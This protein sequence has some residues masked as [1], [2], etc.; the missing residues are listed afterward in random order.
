VRDNLPHPV[1]GQPAPKKFGS[2]RYRA[3]TQTILSK[4]ARNSARQFATF[5]FW[6]PA[7]TIEFWEYLES[8]MRLLNQWKCCV[9]AAVSCASILPS[10]YAAEMQS[11]SIR[12][13]AQVGD[14]PFACGKTYTG[15]G[16]TKAEISPRDFRFYVQSV[17]L[18]DQKGAAVPLAL[19]S[20][21]KWQTDDVALLDFEDGTGRCLNGTPETNDQIIGTVPPGHYTGLRFL[22]GVPFQEN[23]LELTTLPSPLNI[24]ALSWVWNA[25][26]KFARIE[27]TSTGL[28][29][30]YFLHLGS[31][32]CTPNTTRTTVPTKCSSPNRAGVEIS[33]FDVSKDVVVADLATLLRDTDLNHPD[34]K[35]SAGC[36][37]GPKDEDCAA[38]FRNFGLA[39][40]TEAPTT[41]TFFRKAVGGE[42]TST[43]LRP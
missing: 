39:F 9:M 40:G 15:V 12:F 4:L 11:V 14:Q 27:L 17:E 6:E 37:S 29:R 22:V 25:G 28:P 1:W 42:A 8:K 38:V 5:R 32:G 2:Y 19:T 21:G 16:A 23:H 34:E 24:T 20:D 43:A 30:G 41:Q 13:R 35:G 31:T 10:L 33:N 3:D 18:L 7:A 36:M 26:H